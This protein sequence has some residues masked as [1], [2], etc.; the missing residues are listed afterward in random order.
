MLLF[1]ILLLLFIGVGFLLKGNVKI[2]KEG[3]TKT[4][5]KM[6]LL[7]TFSIMFF[8]SAFK[9]LDVGVD[10]KHYFEIFDWIKNSNVLG[11]YEP[12]FFYLSKFLG[13]KVGNFQ[14][15]I[16][17][18]SM[19][20]FIPFAIYIYFESKDV[21]FSTLIFYLVYFIS[22]NTMMRQ[23][24]AMGISM[25]ALLCYKRKHY[26]ISI[27]LVIIA[28]SF[29]YS[30][31]ILV[32]IPFVSYMKYN[33]KNLIYCIIFA[34]IVARFN[35]I[36][37][38]FGFFNIDSMYLEN[39]GAGGADALLQTLISIVTVCCFYWSGSRK[40]IESAQD[41][42]M[43][44]P[45]YEN[46]KIRLENKNNYRIEMWA[47]F[48]YVIFYILTITFPV[49]SRFS[50]YFA[51]GFLVALPNKLSNEKNGNIKFIVY[52]LILSAYVIYQTLVFIFRPAWGGV[53]PYSFCWEM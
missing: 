12:G 24:M 18:S 25:I 11:R 14:S 29:H 30:A 4:G 26:L 40:K 9:S 45:V 28:I 3:L 15:L 23:G 35:L 32:I 43:L 17:V 34:I 22:F 8:L 10:T 36:D 38:L 7:V 20:M 19:V 51:F 44:E 31:I 41:R 27:I 5:R 2:G 47:I 50:S 13:N 49:A 39:A 6:Y 46:S 16:I 42:F 53:F 52:C 37:I 48:L 33:F 1:Y 21:V